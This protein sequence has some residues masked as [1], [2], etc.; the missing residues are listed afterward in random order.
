M[1]K[2]FHLLGCSLL[3]VATPLVAQDDSPLVPDFVNRVQLQALI[4]PQ[5]SW[6]QGTYYPAC[7][8]CEHKDGAGSGLF[9]GIGA[10]YVNN[11]TLVFGAYLTFE[12]R[13]LSASYIRINNEV[14]RSQQTN[15]SY[16]VVAS[17]RYSSDVQF[18]VL[19]AMPYLRL[20]P[21][22]GNFYLRAGASVGVVLSNHITNTKSLLDRMY[23]LPDGQ[24]IEV[25]VDESKLSAG[26]TKV[27][28]YTVRLEDGEFQQSS[29]LQF[30]L[31]AATG[32]NFK[33]S[34]SAYLGPVIQFNLPMTDI[35]PQ[36]DGFR[37]PGMLFM[38]E[39]SYIL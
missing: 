29:G 33:L 35:N 7:K 6:Q 5:T 26:Q 38:L 4:G 3:L 15:N 17:S 20:Y 23:K 13:N 1:H 27:D 14:V 28:L 8:E 36:G 11:E 34:K 16:S 25:Q 19:S 18:S 37:I 24:T 32:Y 30:S 21:F 22:G 39:F 9:T 12:T 10:E 2:L 31:H